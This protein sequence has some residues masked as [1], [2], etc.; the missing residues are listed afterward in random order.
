[1][2]APAVQGHCITYILDG[3]SCTNGLDVNCCNFLQGTINFW[4]PYIESIRCVCQ[5]LLI[6]GLPATY[7]N[8]CGVVAGIDPYC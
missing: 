7:L 2:V 4:N 5:A 8:D 1:M 6:A 3:G